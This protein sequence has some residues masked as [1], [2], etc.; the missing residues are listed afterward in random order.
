LGGEQTGVQ[1]SYCTEC[2]GCADTNI[3]PARFSVVHP[4]DELTFAMVEGVLV[5]GPRCQPAC[6]PTL[7]IDR[8]DCDGLEH[9][10]RLLTEDQSWT[11]GLAPGTYWIWLDTSFVADD[12]ETGQ[13]YTG[14][15]L[16]IDASVE[17]SVV[18]AKEAPQAC[19]SS[20]VD[21]G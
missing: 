14:F 10:D 2:G 15:G 3:E 6:P 17:R 12:G 5:T 13:T 7:R 20:T 8:I 18:D 16:V 21:A 11:V 4:G 1:G 19:A 9:V